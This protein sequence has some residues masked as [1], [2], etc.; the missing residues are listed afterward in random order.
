MKFYN[1]NEF[2]TIKTTHGG[3]YGRCKWCRGRGCIACPSEIIKHARQAIEP[4]FRA[5][6]ENEHDLELLKEYFGAS[7][8]QH[9]F[10]PDGDGI[11][12][13]LY[14]AAIANLL[15]EIMRCKDETKY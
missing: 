11:N 3:S 4:L 6:I 13:I 8:I 12:E 2:R 7:A 1:G 5:D 10:G 15:Q 14:N 9:A